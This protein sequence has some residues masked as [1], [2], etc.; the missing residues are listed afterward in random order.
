MVGAAMFGP[1][2][3]GGGPTASA[4]PDVGQTWDSATAAACL[5][6]TAIAWIGVGV[7]VTVVIAGVVA[8][9]VVAI[10]RSLERAREGTTCHRRAC[11]PPAR[12]SRHAW[13]AWSG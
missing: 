6:L 4:R 2:L 10:R 5:D 11:S 8:A 7:V 1:A 13:H 9:I 12:R 3:L